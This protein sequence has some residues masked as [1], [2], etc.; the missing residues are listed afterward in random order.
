VAVTGPRGHV[1]LQAT[2]SPLPTRNAT[3]SAVAV[4]TAI[5]VFDDRGQP[6]AS[7]GLTCLVRPAGRP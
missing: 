2:A 5:E 7:A 3:S 1:T 4:T 6:T